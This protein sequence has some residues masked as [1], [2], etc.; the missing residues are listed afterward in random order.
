MNS[1]EE[2]VKAVLAS[3][4]PAMEADGGGVELVEVDGDNVVVRFIGTC[5][6]CPSI[7][8]TFKHG[9]VKALAENLNWIKDVSMVSNW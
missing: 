1:R 2:Q 7:G 3:L 6:A 5:L 4:Q 8:M 9:V